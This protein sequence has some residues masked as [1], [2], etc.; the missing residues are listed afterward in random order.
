MK[1]TPASTAVMINVRFGMPS[2]TRAPR[3]P[4]RLMTQSRYS[5]YRAL[6]GTRSHNLHP[7]GVPLTGVG[8]RRTRDNRPEYAAR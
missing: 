5:N 2:N 6:G 4:L 7:V 8:R 1:R 3:D